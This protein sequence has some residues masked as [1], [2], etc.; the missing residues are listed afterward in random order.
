MSV[1]KVD[2]FALLLISVCVIPQLTL[3]VGAGELNVRIGV[4]NGSTKI[5]HI[6]SFHQELG[7]VE[8][9]TQ[10]RLSPAVLLG[11]YQLDWLPK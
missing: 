5:Y 10:D 11:G 1:L 9:H 7:R 3:Q 2:A 6:V 4:N 8:E